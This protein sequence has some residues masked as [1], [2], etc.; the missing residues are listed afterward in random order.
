MMPIRTLAAAACA[1][2]VLGL[3]AA[4]TAAPLATP[5]DCDAA[6]AAADRA[7]SEFEAMKSEYLA[8][9]ADGGHPDASQRQALA[10]ADV[11][12]ATA[13][14]EAERICNAV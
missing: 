8:Q 7:E 1:A 14:A 11:A 5:A 2:T 4:A 6:Q 13:R 10:D 9:I 3:P 12:R